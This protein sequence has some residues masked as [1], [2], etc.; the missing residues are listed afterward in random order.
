MLEHVL[1]LQQTN[2]TFETFQDSSLLTNDNLTLQQHSLP[3]WHAPGGKTG[4]NFI[5]TFTPVSE[6][7]L[8]FHPGAL[9]ASVSREKSNKRN[10]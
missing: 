1:G 2:L 6:W 10:K 5:S 4:C 7:P 8:I 3:S 9:R